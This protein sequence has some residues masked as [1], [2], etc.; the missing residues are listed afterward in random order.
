MRY[1]KVV[2]EFLQ[3][4]VASKTVLL[5][6]LVRV[7]KHPEVLGAVR[8]ASTLAAPGATIVPK[9]VPNLPVP[10][11]DESSIDAALEMDLAAPI[12]LGECKCP[13]V[14]P[15]QAPT[16]QQLRRMYPVMR[17]NYEKPPWE[18]CDRRG[19]FA[20]DFCTDGRWDDIER[21][22]GP[23]VPCYRGSMPLGSTA[24]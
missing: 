20:V 16:L 3:G 18:F 22:H 9:L 14:L 5:S 15:R 19:L 1:R 10:Y 7:D 8:I 13:G 11:L 21:H 6:M 24:R 23:G 4:S 2:P 17:G 12:L